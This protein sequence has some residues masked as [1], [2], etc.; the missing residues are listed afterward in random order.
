[1]RFIPDADKPTAAWDD[2]LVMRIDVEEAATR[3]RHFERSFRV[4]GRVGA[5]Q[6][7]EVVSYSI[8]PIEVRNIELHR[9]SWSV[10]I[11]FGGRLGPGQRVYV[12]RTP[13]GLP[14]A[15]AGARRIHVYENRLCLPRRFPV[16]QAVLFDDN[17]Q[18]VEALRWRAGEYDLTKQVLMPR[19]D[20]PLKDLEFVSERLHLR[21]GSAYVSA[22]GLGAVRSAE[23]RPDAASLPLW[24]MI[25]FVVG[26]GAY[27]VAMGL[28]RPEVNPDRTEYV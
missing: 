27:A 23:A 28:W 8:R 21:S 13:E 6:L 18:V 26:L 5:R 2:E 11:N 16:E 19:T 17:E 1:V 15:V 14:P 9:S 24:P 22:N 25:L 10:P 3:W 20:R 4:P 7:F 12:D